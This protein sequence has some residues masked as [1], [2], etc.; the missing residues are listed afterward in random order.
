M[1]TPLLPAGDAA[2]LDGCAAIPADARQAA[3]H[4]ASAHTSSSLRRRPSLSSRWHPAIPATIEPVPRN[5][6]WM[7]VAIVLFVAIGM[8]V[9]ITKLA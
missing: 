8:I 1:F 6:I 9:A 7:Q 2:I 3:A 5:W 4:S